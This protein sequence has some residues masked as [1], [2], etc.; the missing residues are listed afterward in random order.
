MY[1]F[2][3]YFID[4]LQI[5]QKNRIISKKVYRYITT[6]HNIQKENTSAEYIKYYN[7][8]IVQCKLIAI[9]LLKEHENDYLLNGCY[10]YQKD[11]SYKKYICESELK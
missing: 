10:L 6:I 1:K 2:N 7:K 11:G 8:Y 4:I 5:Q 9:H 3:I